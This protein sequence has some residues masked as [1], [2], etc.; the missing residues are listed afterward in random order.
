MGRIVVV[1]PEWL[2]PAFR[3]AD[4]QLIWV[5]GGFGAS[6]HSRGRSVFAKTL[7][8]GDEFRYYREDLMG[9]LKP[10]HIPAWATEKLAQLQADK[11]PSK[12]RPRDEAR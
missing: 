1:R 10:E 2:R 4:Y 12:P 5:T 9:F 11:A 7:Y 8:S 3:T 6:G